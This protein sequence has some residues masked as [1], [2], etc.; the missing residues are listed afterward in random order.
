MRRSALRYQYLACLLLA[1]AGCSDEAPISDSPP[2][3]DPGSLSQANMVDPSCTMSCPCGLG[4]D[5]VS[6]TCI[7]PRSNCT[8]HAFDCGETDLDC[9]GPC[10]NGCALN[11]HCL[12]DHDCAGR[13]CVAT[14]CKDR[15][16]NG[17]LDDTES[18]LDCGDGNMGPNIQPCPRCVD[19]KYA[20][21][22]F[23]CVSGFHD[24]GLTGRTYPLGT[25]MEYP[26]N[27]N[28][29]PK[30]PNN[31][32]GTPSYH[33]ES[34]IVHR[35]GDGDNN[36]QPRPL[37]AEGGGQCARCA[38]S[39]AD[40]GMNHPFTGTWY[41]CRF[42]SDCTSNNCDKQ[43]AVGV[44][45]VPAGFGVC[46]PPA[47]CNMNGLCEPALGETFGTCPSD[48]RCLN[49]GGCNIFTGETK[50]TCP[51][52]NCSNT[53]PPDMGVSPPDMTVRPPDLFTS[54]DMVK[55]PDL[56]VPPD[57]SAPCN[58]DGKCDPGEIFGTCVP[59]CL[60]NMNG[61]CNPMNGETCN[62]CA[63][64][65]CPNIC[66]NGLC[67]GNENC[68]SCPQDCKCGPNK[69]CQNNACVAA[70]IT[71]CLA[72]ALCRMYCVKGDP[73]S[74]RRGFCDLNNPVNAQYEAAAYAYAK[75]VQQNFFNAHGQNV[76]PQCAVNSA[77]DADKCA[78]PMG[79]NSI[80]DRQVMLDVNDNYGNI[81]CAAQ[82]L[83]C[84]K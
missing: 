30:N 20:I 32:A 21:N 77:E 7:M 53:P 79:F 9:G 43:V 29:C 54:P 66:P 35:C 34:D 31:K 22:D 52:S 50:R 25:Q 2:A 28:P 11:K 19:G 76:L 1:L 84:P 78:P 13:Y 62:N 60:C 38:N 81:G 45:V 3:D 24:E 57:L 5:P 23:S 48:C 65:C 17:V 47:A 63:Q 14:V 71:N 44:A 68:G 61:S 80:D 36:G 83:A 70:P 73:C 12:E 26:C 18:D 40:F 46:M 56:V 67:D 51:N 58:H 10:I 37:R 42:N 74:S 15:C 39:I 4:C 55:L 64:D 49:M 59:D 8:D 41:T 6:H 27:S 75:C 72:N 82:F 16:A 69:V 33:W